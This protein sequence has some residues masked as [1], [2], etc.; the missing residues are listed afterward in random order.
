MGTLQNSDRTLLQLFVELQILGVLKGEGG[1]GE[2]EDSEK[3]VAR[4]HL[5]WRRHYTP[6]FQTFQTIECV[7]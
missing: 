1:E 7:L 4:V 5:P 3:S 6:T 2:G